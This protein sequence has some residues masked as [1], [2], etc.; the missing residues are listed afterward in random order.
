MYGLGDNT[1]EKIFLSISF[2]FGMAVNAGIALIKIVDQS[3]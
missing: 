1:A 2:E 3:I